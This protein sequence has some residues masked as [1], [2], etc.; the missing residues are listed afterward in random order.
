MARTKRKKLV[1]TDNV[2][3]FS[4]EETPSNPPPP[5]R[6]PKRLVQTGQQIIEREN[7][8]KRAHRKAVAAGSGPE[9][10]RKFLKLFVKKFGVKH[11]K[12]RWPDGEIDTNFFS[13]FD[14]RDIT[15]G[16]ETDELWNKVKWAAL[17]NECPPT[18]VP[19]EWHVYNPKASA[20]LTEKKKPINP[21]ELTKAKAHVTLQDCIDLMYDLKGG[22]KLDG[23]IIGYLRA[24]KISPMIASTTGT[25]IAGIRNLPSRHQGLFDMCN[26]RRRNPAYPR[27]ED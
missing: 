6:G 9:M 11:L 16:R 5:K 27:S 8:A 15:M 13:W 10:K 26:L 19:P 14:M 18:T 25:M 24:Q 22:K 17:E 7:A 2:A 21:M 20:Q 12:K 3:G 4:L 23:A 1:A